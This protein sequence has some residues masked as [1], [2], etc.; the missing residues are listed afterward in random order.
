M[1]IMT[2]AKIAAWQE[3]AGITP[4]TGGRAEILRE[5]SNAAFEAIKIIAL[6]R[7]GIR[8]GDGFWHGSDVIGNMT[9]ELTDLCHQLMTVDVEAAREVEAVAPA[10]G[11]IPF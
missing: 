3:A 11:D 7:S 1:S 2:E 5:L 10:R 6:E 9:S 8:D 4:A